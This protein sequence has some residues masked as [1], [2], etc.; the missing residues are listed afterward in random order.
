MSLQ[1]LNHLVSFDSNI[2]NNIINF[3]YNNKKDPNHLIRKQSQRA[4]SYE[5]L[6]ICLHYGSRKKT[7]N[8]YSYT[9]TDRCLYNSIYY[10][11]LHKLRGL[12]IIG[13]WK[14]GQFTPITSYYNFNVRSV[15]RF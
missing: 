2:Q 8:K 6:L 13:V 5:M 1:E 15:K 4:I 11:F 10:K 12:T 3:N 7:Y 14:K 9:L